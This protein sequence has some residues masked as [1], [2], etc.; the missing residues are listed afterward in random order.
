MI[1]VIQGRI[2]PI[3]QPEETGAGNSNQKDKPSESCRLPSARP[4]S[5]SCRRASSAAPPALRDAS[6]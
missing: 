1:R 5:K 3:P 2:S 4:K 6:V